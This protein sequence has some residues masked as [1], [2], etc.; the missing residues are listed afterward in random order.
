MPE[1]GLV[2][3]TLLW[4]LTFPLLR[5]IV[6]TVPPTWVVAIRFSITFLI[7]IPIALAHGRSRVSAETRRNWKGALVLGVL[8]FL[9]YLTQT[10]G[11]ET[12]GA[13]RAAF[14]TGTCVVIV[15]LIAPLFGPE[16]PLRSDWIACAVAVA[17]LFLLTRPDQGCASLGGDLWVLGCAV[18]CALYIRVLPAISRRSDSRHTL[19]LLQTATVSLLAWGTLPVTGGTLPHIDSETWRAILI[20][21]TF[22]TTGTFT[23]QTSCQA[24]TR[25]ER[26]A[27]IFALEPVWASLF[28][29]LLLG[30]KF[31]ASGYLGAGLIL[32]SVLGLE[33]WNW[34]VRLVSGPATT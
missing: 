30:E 17:G 33:L 19:N 31:T 6:Q 1:L 29:Y 22:I 3:T 23:L 10:K 25:P 27:I 24:R 12:I 20:L 13:G 11:L 9:S 32:A 21:A 28:G 8:A 4:G 26:A 2:L 16:R 15:P 7:F 18:A 34:R 5:M 14:I